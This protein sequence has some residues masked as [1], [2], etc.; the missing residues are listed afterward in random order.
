MFSKKKKSHS[1]MS[2]FPNLVDAHSDYGWIQ[3]G[4]VTIQIKSAN[5]SE[6]EK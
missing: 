6:T 5:R 2:H 3:L 4:N 1:H